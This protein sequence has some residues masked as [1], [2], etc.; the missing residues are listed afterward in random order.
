M[1]SGKFRADV[2]RPMSDVL[3]STLG[4]LFGKEPGHKIPGIRAKGSTIKSRQGDGGE[5]YGL[6]SAARLG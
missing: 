3:K 2:E 4:V 5:G 6:D 1:A